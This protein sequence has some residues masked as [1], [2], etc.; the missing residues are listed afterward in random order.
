MLIMR[1]MAGWLVLRFG[2][3]GPLHIQKGEEQVTVRA[4]KQRTVLALLLIHR[5]GTVPTERLISEL[6]DHDP[7]VSAR[8][9]LQSLVSRLRRSLGEDRATDGRLLVG[10]ASGYAFALPD[11]A[12][13]DLQEFDQAVA[14][15]RA[16][17]AAGPAAD[18]ADDLADDV[19]RALDLW[20][21]AAFADVPASPR[22]V[23]ERTRLEEARLALWETRADLRLARRLNDEV[24]AE[25]TALLADHPLRERLW[26]QL[27][28]AL[29]RSG[30]RHEALTVY[31]DAERLLTAELGIGPGE[32][33]RRLHGQVLAGS[34]P[35]AAPE[36]RA[37]RLSASPAQLP[38]AIPDFT[39]REEELARALTVLGR[40]P[41]GGSAPTVAVSGMAGVGKT[42][43]ALQVAHRLRGNFPDGQIYVDLWSG[44][45]RPQAQSPD[46]V[47]LRFLRAIGMTGRDV[48]SDPDER[49][50]VYRSALANRRIL[51]VI[52]NATD[53]AQVE[54]LLPG[55][56]TCAVLVTSRK[57]LSGLSGARHIV[58]D[59]LSAGQALDLIASVVGPDRLA[60]EPATAAEL[61]DLCGR[62]PLS[63]RIC[64]SRLAARPHWT[65]GT[66]TKRLLD[67][68][69]RID[70]LEYGRKSVRASFTLSYEALEARAR[71]L[72]CLLS[73]VEAEDFAA[74]VAAPLLDTTVR[75]GEH[76]LEVL[77][78]N[79]LVQVAGRDGAGQTRYRLHDLIHL[80]SG[81]LAE[82][83][84]PVSERRD[85]VARLL[86]AWLTLTDRAHETSYGANFLL[87]H[88]TF[89]RWPLAPAYVGQLLADPWAWWE[90]E[91]RSLV[92]MVA[93]AARACLDEAAW[94]LAVTSTTL[95]G[96]YG[97]LGDW[98]TTHETAFAATVR[99]GNRRGE[100]IVMSH[101]AGLRI[102]QQ[103]HTD[104]LD[105]LAPAADTLARLG[106]RRAEAL[107]YVAM[108]IAERGRRDRRRALS[109]FH[110]GHELLRDRGDAL[111]EAHVLL[112]T[113]Q[114]HLA[115]G[116][117]MA[118]ERSLRS[119]RSIARS[120]DGGPLEG[121]IDHWLGSAHL[122]RHDAAAAA[123]AFSRAVTRVSSIGDA[124]AEAMALQGLAHAHLQSGERDTAEHVLSLAGAAAQR[125]PDSATA[126]R[127]LSG[128]GRLLADLRA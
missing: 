38:P 119:A 124:R 85:A 31:G 41:A 68:R 39:G 15:I 10:N 105:L 18:L 99:S 35:P 82:R 72:F 75:E 37:P 70:E 43:F 19:D 27:M 115:L 58:L 54:P 25:N 114:T 6:W 74:W 7:P 1:A 84:I 21:G 64:S 91:H 62:H 92:A 80:Y 69:L 104:A 109:H 125:I 24:I 121:Y 47:V 56:P 123:E 118:A 112:H 65:I 96:T 5:G 61:V 34:V 86:G 50:A 60:R 3:L 100:A 97:Y 73:L 116:D 40:A 106:E 42:T 122:G 48:P 26:E 67:E 55:G 81:D 46:E 13:L 2:V 17:S 20:R 126:T 57:P 63:L 101:L 53:E 14:G 36:P 44:E 52:D 33:L 49:V 95:F 23:V 120:V 12:S 117:L 29:Y 9:T 128:I 30:R 98:Q 94:D 113:G 8:G 90:S 110:R 66:L 11:D 88:G 76:H 102:Y 22:I 4:A 28:L 77:V 127:T 16:R 87:N 108:G 89:P 111:A 59:V 93:Q 32:G 78:E 45:S 71:R 83:H 51:I 103:R 107:C 79:Q